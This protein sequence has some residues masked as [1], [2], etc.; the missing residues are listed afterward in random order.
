M[1]KNYTLLTSDRAHQLEKE[2]NAHLDVGWVFIGGIAM[3]KIEVSDSY[4]NKTDETRWS[5]AMGHESKN[6]DEAKYSRWGKR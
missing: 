3:S 5:Q 4:S 2:V 1:I 6:P